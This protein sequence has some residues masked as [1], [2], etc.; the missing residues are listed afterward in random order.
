MRGMNTQGIVI[1]LIDVPQEYTEAY[2]RWYDFD[3]LPEFATLPGMLLGRRYVALPE[4]KALRPLSPLPELADG[5]GTYC[6]TYL[7]GD[8]DFD[9]VRK[10]WRERADDLM[11]QR[12]MFRHGKL[13][14]V[15]FYRLDYTRVRDDI[16]ASAEAAPHLRDT[17]I[18]IV[19]TEVADPARR[20]KVDQWFLETHAPDLL[21]VHG[22][23]AAMRFSRVDMPAG[24]YVNLYMLEGDPLETLQ[25]LERRIPDWQARGRSPAPGGSSQILFQSVYRPVIPM[26]YDFLIE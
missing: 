3:H 7:I 6:T 11:K 24:R 25:D 23:I 4:Y 18:M 9:A 16:P 2:N 5:R 19:M 12:R 13:A 1:G 17:G 10:R 22:V 8:D 15:G 14:D 21:E 20:G 26:Q